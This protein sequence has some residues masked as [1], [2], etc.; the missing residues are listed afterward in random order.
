MEGFFEKDSS[1]LY[2]A[3]EDYNSLVALKANKF[4]K[5][6]IVSSRVSME[7]YKDRKI[8]LLPHS[9]YMESIKSLYPKANKVIAV[10][11]GVRDELSKI[12]V[13]AVTIYNGIDVKKIEALAQEPCEYENFLL[14]VGRID[15]GQKGQDDTLKAFYKI[16]KE[17]D[18]NL[19]FI[20]DGK[21]FEKLE[22]MVLELGLT[23]RVFL[24]GT[25]KNPYKFLKKCDILIFSSYFEGM[26]NVVLEAMAVGAAII[27][28]DFLPSAEELSCEGKYFPLIKRGDI[29]SLANGIIDIL[30]NEKNRGKL[31]D[32]SIKRSKSYSY[33]AMAQRWG[34]VLLGKMDKVVK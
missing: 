8:H 19:I 34:S 3:F 14:H 18:K 11:N 28:Y 10:S 32:L 20:G 6:I 17:V 29:V 22:N 2:I 25:Q 15:F 27:S 21:D 5:Q 7:F 26:P 1:D 33:E 16:H 9:F 31:K 24:L 30:G 12:G 4:D 13:D 23:K